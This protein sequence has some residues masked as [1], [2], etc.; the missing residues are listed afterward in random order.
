MKALLSLGRYGEWLAPMIVAVGIS[1]P[2]FAQE[3]EVLPPPYKGRYYEDPGADWS[4]EEIMDTEVFD[5]EG[6]EIGSVE[7]L[8]INKKGRVVAVVAQVGGLWDIGDIHVAV[9][10]DEVQMEDK[11]IILPITEDNVGDYSLFTEEYFTRHDVGEI[12]TVDDDLTTGPNIWKATSLLD[13]YAVLENNVGYGY[14]DDLIFND[15]GQLDSVLVNVANPDYGYGYYTYPWYGYGY[16][17]YA[18]HPGLDY[19]VLPYDD[20]LADLN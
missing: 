17:S 10:W 2:A 8:L 1:L 18:W 7:N 15:N 12:T 11:N 4:A 6:E 19:Y 9:P 13:D 3:D 5:A 20:E 16:G 14:V